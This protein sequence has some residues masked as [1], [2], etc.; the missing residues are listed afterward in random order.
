MNVCGELA[1][2]CK[3]SR[4]SGQSYCLNM[5]SRLR[6]LIGSARNARPILRVASASNTMCGWIMSTASS[7]APRA[8]DSLSL[9]SILEC[10]CVRPPGVCG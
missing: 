6:L 10:A 9:V 3:T 8:N 5:L 7:S 4:G 2:H 1:G